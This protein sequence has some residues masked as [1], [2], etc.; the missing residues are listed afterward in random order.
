VAIINEEAARRHWP[1]RNPIG[2]QLHLGARLVSGP[3]RQKTIV[4]V[5]GDV[6]TAAERR[7]RPRSICPTR[8]I[9]STV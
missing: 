5:V 7:R 6:N 4:G 9:R 1:G 8:S 3:Q 2:E